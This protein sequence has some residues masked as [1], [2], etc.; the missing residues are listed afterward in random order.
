MSEEAP[1]PQRPKFRGS[2]QPQHRL[3]AEEAQRQGN[4]ARLAWSAFQDK[5]RVVAFLNGH[6]EALGGRPIDLAVASDAGLA[7]VT[8]AINVSA[9]QPGGIQA[10]AHGQ[11]SAAHGPG[12][13][14]D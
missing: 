14:T 9:V 6:D 7:A 1:A 12:S 3:T 4:V 5:D 8:E 10:D 2:R 11:A 13:P